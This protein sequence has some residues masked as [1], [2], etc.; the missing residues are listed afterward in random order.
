MN[1]VELATICFLVVLVFMTI[2][3]IY[4]MFNNNSMIREA[5]YGGN[6]SCYPYTAEHNAK[7]SYLS[8]SKGWCTSGDYK[9][10]DN[11]DDFSTNNKGAVKCPQGYYKIQ[12]FDSYDTDTKTWCKR[13][14]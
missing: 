10:I 11:D 9:A 6:H 2:L 7:N 12:P 13:S 14:G 5:F 1:S 4:V 3:T 8:K